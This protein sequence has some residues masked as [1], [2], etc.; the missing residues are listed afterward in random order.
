MMLETFSPNPN[1]T[2]EFSEGQKKALLGSL[3]SEHEEMRKFQAEPRRRWTKLELYLSGRQ[4]KD[5]KNGN[6]VGHEIA[7]AASETGDV[8]DEYFIINDTRRIHLQNMQRLTSYTIQASVIP[9]SLD[10]EDKEAARLGRMVLNT[11]FDE[12]GEKK[13]KRRVARILGLYGVCFFK[14]YFDPSAGRIIAPLKLD[15]LGKPYYDQSDLRPEGRVIIEAVS[16][17]NVLLPAAATDVKKADEV[18]HV[19]IESL[20]YIWRRFKMNVKAENITFDQWDNPAGASSIGDR[21]EMERLAPKNSVL[22]RT[23]YILPCPRFQ[24][25]AIITYCENHIL[26]AATYM[27]HYNGDEQ[28]WSVAE[29]Q[30]DDRT[31]IG[32]S[33]L[34]DEIPVQDALNQVA[35]AMTNHIKMFGDGQMTIPSS[36]G[37]D[38]DKITNK[39]GRHLPYNGK[40]KPEPIEWPEL[41]ETHFRVFEGMRTIGQSLTASHDIARVNKAQSGNAISN[42]QEID[43]TVIRP[44]LDSIEGALSE[45]GKIA[46]G[47]V[48]D[49]YTSNRLVKMTGME[50]WQIENAFRGDKLKGNWHAKISCM[51]GMPT[52]PSYKR[53][54]ILA[55]SKA[56]L[57]ERDEARVN[58]EFGNTDD[59]MEDIQKENEVAN[60]IVKGICSYPDNYVN[61][62]V[63]GDAGPVQMKICK[64]IFHEF[65]NHDLLIKKLLRYMRESYDHEPEPV[66]RTLKEHLEFHQNFLATAMIPPRPGQG[67]HPATMMPP[68][69]GIPPIQPPQG[70]PGGE[71]SRGTP[72]ADSVHSSEEQ[73]N[74]E[75]VPTPGNTAMQATP[76]GQK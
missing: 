55:L 56:G 21:T 4:V 14:T 10:K 74:R 33:L 24:R 67:P 27:D 28:M 12:I 16:P 57:I 1:G 52:N 48:E 65:D 23:R 75:M 54:T 40:E 37:L 13:F 69:G 30:Y 46:L 43:D 51:T 6:Y 22:L 44:T 26:E 62:T 61:T 36:A 17:R 72:G 15:S 71:V 42:L 76:G 45:Q 8:D 35:T 39:S 25:G 31:P 53:E 63:Q 7:S 38:A 9:N 41:S 18:E 70:A 47:L 34:W 60:S 59:L 5:G 49:H 64:T 2:Y 3:K 19:T 29:C 20:Q 32:E 58:L 50:G 68:A 11:I 66:K 73:P